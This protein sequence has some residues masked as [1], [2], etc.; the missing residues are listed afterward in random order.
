MT[1]FL[2]YLLVRRCF[3][4]PLVAW[5]AAAMLLAN[6]YWVVHSRQCRYYPLSGLFMMLM[7]IAFMRW[8]AGRAFGRALFVLSAWCW[9]QTDYGSFWPV[10]GIL[11]AAA[12][13]TS[14]R[15]IRPVLLVGAALGAS[16]AP[17]VWY[18]DLA[19]RLHAGGVPWSDKFLLNLFHMNQ[20][21]I[22]MVVLL[23]AVAVLRLRWHALAPAARMMLLVSLAILFSALV[24]IPSV[25]PYAFHRY[26]VHLSPLAALVTAWVL[27]EGAAFAAARLRWRE[28]FRYVAAG[29]AAAFLVVFP[30]VSNVVA[31]PLQQFIRTAPTGDFVRPEWSVLAEEVFA[32][33]GDPNRKVIETLRPLIAPGD[34]ILVNYEDVPLM[35]YTDNAIRGGLPCFRVEDRSKPPPRFLVYRRSVPFVHTAVFAREIGR[36]RWRVIHTGAPDVPWGNIPEPELRAP[37]DSPSIPEVI[38]AENV[39][40]HKP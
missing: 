14:R 2:L 34:E 9:F 39:G 7:L 24:W 16:I 22:A 27:C 8:Q 12:A 1:V 26:I 29:A 36:Y 15:R 3:D 5:L 4:D 21:L 25:T 38:V 18:Y 31:Y 30:F 13:W 28:S 32:P 6:V 35:F 11:L 40:A 23:G 17:W 33:Q 10:T 20:F 37:P 19:G